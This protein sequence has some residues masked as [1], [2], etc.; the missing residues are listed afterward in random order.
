MNR[1]SSSS[2]NSCEM[3]EFGIQISY[4]KKLSPNGRGVLRVQ[5]GW[6]AD[7]QSDCQS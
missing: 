6:L 4:S 3:K 2:N 5:K 1:I 7:C